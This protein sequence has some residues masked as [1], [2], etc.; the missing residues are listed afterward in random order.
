MIMYRVYCRKSETYMTGDGRK[1]W[2]FTFDLNAAWL[3][4]TESK[5]KIIVKTYFCD[6]CFLDIEAVDITFYLISKDG[7]YV[8]GHGP[9]KDKS[10]AKRFYNKDFAIKVAQQI[11]GNIIECS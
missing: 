7:Q 4:K 10:K 5:A 8:N 9:V 3:F 11:G 2:T 1:N 6:E